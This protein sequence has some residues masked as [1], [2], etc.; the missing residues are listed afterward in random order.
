MKTLLIVITSLLLTA[1]DLCSC[2]TT[3][4][5]KSCCKFCQSRGTVLDP[6]SYIY[7]S[8]PTSE[9]SCLNGDTTVLKRN[10]VVLPA[11]K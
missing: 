3:W 2:Q 4:A 1:C 5:A 7:S 10:L 9:C 11:E 8:G 6:G